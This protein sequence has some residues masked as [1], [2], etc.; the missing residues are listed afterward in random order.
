MV[1]PACGVA[2]SGDYDVEHRTV[3]DFHRVQV[4]DNVAVELVVDRHLDPGPVSL[5]LSGDDNLLDNVDTWVSG[6][7][8]FVT[9]DRLLWPDI[10]LRVSGTVG[11]LD[12][13]TAE[14][15][16]MLRLNGLY[17]NDF[18]IRTYD[19]AEAV[20]SGNVER[21]DVYARDRS[22]VDALD[23]RAERV[24]VDA[25]DNAEVMVCAERIVTG[26]VDG[27]AAVDV[28]CDPAFVDLD[29]YGVIGF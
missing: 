4:E 17:G 21:L 23:L 22:D 7:T 18:A 29:G 6:E 1:L 16:S 19:W 25:D 15:D 26:D 14:N 2:G 5:T 27:W 8:L 12:G 11:D 3:A 9:T 10:E 20:L 24:T 13:A 28:Y